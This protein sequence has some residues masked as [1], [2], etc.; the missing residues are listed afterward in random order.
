M[1]AIFERH[2]QALHRYCYS[3]LNNSH[4]A[5]DALQ[6]TM[7]K[8]LRALPGERRQIALRPW[9]Y[10]IAHNE[11][12]SLLRARRPDGALDA[13]AGVTD[14]A[15]GD[16]VETR[17]R[18][19]TLTADL[20]SLSER[21]RTALLMRELAGLEFSEVA[22]ALGSSASAIKQSVYEARSALHA[23]EEG[24]AMDCEKARRMVSDGDRRRLRGLRM[25]GHL[26]ACAGC[27]D[28]E[29]AL[30]QRPAQLNCLIPALPAAAAAAI[31]QGLS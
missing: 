9:L 19:R 17:E 2:H 13:A 25:R 26:R 14:V 29:I 31:L 15:A 8:A 4:D 30:R 22:D 16:L 3:I 20:E 18:L 10:R 21:Q 1:A 7:I 27:R 5:E 23:M 28:F 11:S 12:I 24:R 6:S